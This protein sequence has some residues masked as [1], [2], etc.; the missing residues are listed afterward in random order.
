MV[1]LLSRVRLTGRLELG[2]QGQ[3]EGGVG[4]TQ[5]ERPAGRHVQEDREA[6][7][8]KAEDMAIKHEGTKLK[9]AA[10]FEYKQVRPSLI[11]RENFLG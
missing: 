3:G 5:G 6:A 2:N 1:R 8:N 11:V 10:G 7:L 9:K 4:D